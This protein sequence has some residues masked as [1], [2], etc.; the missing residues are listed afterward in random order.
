MGSENGGSRGL[1]KG[2][3][4]RKGE[5]Y[6]NF[7]NKLFHVVLKDYLAS[8]QHG[9]LGAIDLLVVLAGG[10]GLLLIVDNGI[11]VVN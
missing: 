10:T 2:E 5:E 9:M 8:R 3:D 4:E 1:L 7:N 11:R 6:F